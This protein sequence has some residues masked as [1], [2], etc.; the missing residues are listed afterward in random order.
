[1]RV[2]VFGT[3]RDTEDWA[4]LLVEGAVEVL[5]PDTIGGLLEAPAELG[6]VVGQP[7]TAQEV[8]EAAAGAETA[9]A[10]TLL[11]GSPGQPHPHARLVRT[12]VRAK[13]DWEAAFDAIVDPVIILE[14][15]GSLR[16]ANLSLASALDRPVAT[17]PGKQYVELLGEAV[18]GSEDPI[19]RSLA[20]GAPRTQEA[21]YS[22][23]PGTRQVTACPVPNGHHKAAL[24]AVLKDVTDFAAQRERMLQGARLADIGQL[25]GGIA[26]EISTPLAS[27]A[28]RAESLARAAQDPRL[29]EIDSFK[30]FARYL[31]T[32]QDET[33]RC[34]R[35]ITALVEF[36]RSRAPVVRDADL[37]ALCGKAADLMRHETRVKQVG[38]TLRLDPGL[39]PVPADES[40]L[41]QALLALLLNA[42]DA[43]SAG[44]QIVIETRREGEAA[45]SLS[46]IDDGVGIPPGNLDRIFNPFFTTKPTGKGAGLGLAICHGV[47]ASHGGEIRVESERGRGSRFSMVLPLTGA[48]PPGIA[49]DGRD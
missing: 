7:G 25:A 37:N 23:L 22:R 29:Q 32:I 35:I 49:S 44:G 1:M 34:K 21:R 17:L 33:F 48:K 26:H 31:Q 27:I 30:N 20:D 9:P 19:G 18:E 46:V 6:I 38:F 47:V 28:L 2:A 11:V 8:A 12:L 24:L 16:R 10:L 39:P 43:T 45:V 14:A 40:R 42:L 15:D 36:A 4:A 41:S 13:R 5:R 3:D